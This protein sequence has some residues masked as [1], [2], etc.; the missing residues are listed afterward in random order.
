MSEDPQYG[1]KPS[2]TKDLE[3]HGIAPEEARRQLALLAHPPAPRELL[4]PCTPGDGIL[5]VEETWQASFV[6][7]FKHA[8]AAGRVAKFVPASGAA[9]RMFRSVSAEHLEADLDRFPFAADLRRGDPALDVAEALLSPRGLNLGAKPK[10]LIPF[11][12]YGDS[13]R[14]AFEEHLVEAALYTADQEGLCRIHVTV[15]PEHEEAFR[16]LFRERCGELEQEHGV[17]FQLSFSHQSPATDTLAGDPEGGPFRTPS[18]S[19]VF[20]PGGHG[21]L[22]HNLA[23]VAGDIVVI[24][25][26]DN[27]VPDEQKGPTVHWKQVLIGLIVELQ[28]KAHALVRA[29]K[30]TPRAEPVLEDARRLV[31]QLGGPS[32]LD[33]ATGLISALDR[34]LRVCGMVRNQGEPG[35]GPFW[36]RHQTEV[37]K[38]IVEGSEVDRSHPDQQEIWESS[39][40]FNPVDLVAALR[41]PWGRP[42]DLTRF[43]DPEAVFIAHK[44]HEGRDLLALERPGLWNGGMARWNTVFVEVPLATFAPVKTVFDL[45][46]PEHQPLP[47][48]DTPVSGR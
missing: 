32:A 22:I 42:Y 20:R 30:E 13:A 23:N 43:T 1:L 15:S 12:I 36:V 9:S 38:Q 18:G 35:G 21:A 31:E 37:S 45:L 40:H 44:S 39:T 46:R 27:V 7:N 5:I 26:I 47:G 19:L 28:Q 41:D 48:S 16:A 8:A 25:N 33:S 17:T 3:S 29:L 6:E 11:H 34:P 24:K 14:T 10:G 4:R 2:D